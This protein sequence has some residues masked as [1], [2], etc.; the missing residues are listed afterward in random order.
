MELLFIADIIQPNILFESALVVLTLS[1]CAIT[2]F[3]SVL[4]CTYAQCGI[5]F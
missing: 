3:L 2:T 5:Q 1:L 4:N